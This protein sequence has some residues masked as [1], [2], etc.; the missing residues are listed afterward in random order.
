MSLIDGGRS[1]LRLELV[2]WNLQGSGRLVDHGGLGTANFADAA[3]VSSPPDL[4]QTLGM[5]GNDPV[6]WKSANPWWAFELI[7]RLYLV[8][9]HR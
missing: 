2:P 5:S 6:P 4:P 1:R 8:Q 7:A 9:A 3:V